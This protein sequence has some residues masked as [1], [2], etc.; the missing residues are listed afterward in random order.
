MMEEDKRYISLALE[1]ARE[2]L[3]RGEVPVGCILLDDNTKEI[4]ARGSNRVNELSDATAHAE[5]V[6]FRQLGKKQ[7]LCHSLTLYVTCEPCIM[8]AAGIVQTNLFRR[9][10]FGCSNPRFGGCGSVKSLQL[11]N[12]GKYDPIPTVTKGVKATEAVQLLA[13]FYTRT[14]PNAPRPKKKRKGKDGIA[15]TSF[16]QK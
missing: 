11:Y 5:M 1:E 6:A 13:E 3:N 9:I 4:I 7:L 14:N 8:C 2:A 10:V 12:N 15:D 16:D